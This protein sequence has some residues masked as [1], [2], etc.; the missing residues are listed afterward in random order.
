MD[1]PTE[2]A[3]NGEND[4]AGLHIARGRP[5]KAGLRREARLRMSG[6]AACRLSPVSTGVLYCWVSQGR[7]LS[8]CWWAPVCN[9]ILPTWLSNAC[10]GRRTLLCSQPNSYTVLGNTHTHIGCVYADTRRHIHLSRSQNNTLHMAE[11]Q[12]ADRLAQTK[13]GRLIL[14]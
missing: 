1:P 13:W 4:N 3:A 8:D 7:R 5:G 11:A 6:L 12:T 2:P 10:E 14:V 9:H